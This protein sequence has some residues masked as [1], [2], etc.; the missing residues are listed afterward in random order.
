LDL[1]LVNHVGT[2]LLQEGTLQQEELKVVKDD[3]TA[4]SK[5]ATGRF[6]V[7]ETKNGMKVCGGLAIARFFARSHST[8]YGVDAAEGK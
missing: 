1:H 3:N 2:L 7:L 4:I 6:P 5:S 8:F